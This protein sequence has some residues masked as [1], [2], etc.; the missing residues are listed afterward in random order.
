MTRLWS[1][2]NG[3]V[4]GSERS[5]KGDVMCMDAV[6]RLARFGCVTGGAALCLLLRP[7]SVSA[8]TIA[9]MIVEYHADHNGRAKGTFAV[10]N[11][12]LFPV[13][14]VLEPLSFNVDEKGDPAYRRLDPS[15]RVRLS[16]ASFRVPPR[17]TYTVAYELETDRLPAW[18]TVYATISLAT[19]D[20]TVKVALRLPHTVYLLP[21]EPLDERAVVFLRSESNREIHA[22]QVEIENTGAQYGRVQQ[23]EVSSPRGKQIFNGFPFFPGQRRTVILPWDD[24]EAPNQVVMRFKA[25]K[26]SHAIDSSGTVY[27]S[28]QK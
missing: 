28:S 15:V 10:G 8:Q 23:V 5:G 20:Q 16:A 6:S 18:F 19:N 2:S 21:K 26:V 4:I 9:P 27:A 12:S 7:P 22:I 11:P 1:L 13:N 25:F 17:Q 3:F 24:S 14:V